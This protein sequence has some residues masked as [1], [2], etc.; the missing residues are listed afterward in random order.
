MA[1]R[2]LIAQR[3]GKRIAGRAAGASRRRAPGGRGNAD[4]AL[5]VLVVVL[6]VMQVVSFAVLATENLKTKRELYFAIANTQNEIN[7]IKDYAE[8]VVSYYD[9][10]QSE[11]LRE[12]YRMLN[13]NEKER[14]RMSPPPERDFSDVYR[15]VVE[16]VVAVTTGKSVGSGFFVH[17]SG[18]VVTNLHVISGKG[19]GKVK[20]V[21][22][23]RKFYDVRVLGVDER[24]D[25]ALLEVVKPDREFKA[26]KLADSQ[27]VRV[28][29]KV[30]AIGNPFGFSFTATQGIVSA[31]HRKGP[32]GL[33]EYLQTDV[34]L[35][36]GNSG[37]PLI[38]SRGEVVGMNNFKIRQSEGIGF[39]LESDAIARF[40]NSALKQSVL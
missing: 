26:L 25:L 32:N 30:L 27:E 31:V 24:R 5:R 29:S 2:K 15:D 33:R 17:P 22:Y 16:G 18:L 10:I 40:V 37:G 8:E 6:A 4:T 20:V 23:D 12:L 3:K 19:K 28:G 14:V 11:N 38:N 35:N 34:P 36:P 13:T 21:T 39:A 7:N 1:S 9:T